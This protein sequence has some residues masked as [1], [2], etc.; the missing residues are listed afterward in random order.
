MTKRFVSLSLF[1]FVTLACVAGENKPENP[2]MVDVT[3]RG[4]ALY[5][6]DQAAWHATDAVQATDH[7]VCAE[8]GRGTCAP[9][10]GCGAPPERRWRATPGGARK[11]G[12]SSIAA[13]IS[14]DRK[15]AVGRTLTGCLRFFA[16]SSCRARWR[17]PCGD[18][19]SGVDPAR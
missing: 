5:E 6:Y 14:P 7:C 15:S 13:T 1:L 4:R 17:K 19:G 16:N 9:P 10:S 3:A 18:A 2:V 11:W 8:E 12:S